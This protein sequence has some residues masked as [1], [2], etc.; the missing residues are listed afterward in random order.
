[1]SMNAKEWVLKLKEENI[2]I[3]GEKNG[4]KYLHLKTPCKVHVTENAV[5]QLRDNYVPKMEKGGVLVAQPKKVGGVTHLTI[6]KVIFITN[7]SDKPE[8]SYRAEEKELNKALKDTYCGKS[9]NTLPIRFHTHPTHS[10]NP[11]NEMM[12]Y[13][14]QCNT[15]EQ[16]QLVSDY[17]VSIGDLSILM[18]RSLVLCGG[19][20]SS[21]FLGFYNGLIAPIEFESL[22]NEKMSEAMQS[23]FKSVSEWA[24]EGNNKWWLI[25]GGVGL[26][27]LM[28]RYPKVIFPMLFMLTAM[29]P[30][31]INAQTA[32]SEESEYFAH[33][34]RK[35]VTIVFPELK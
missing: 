11:M 25:G 19:I 2:L 27:F 1:M 34:T 20:S 32:S 4:K 8:S 30:I 31:L 35:E 17:P 29:A 16:D 14:F 15:S 9:E 23:T 5:K 21:M 13:M 12:S 7:D 26:V 28:I 24:K 18:P 10:D 33:V 3:E 6:D 22:R